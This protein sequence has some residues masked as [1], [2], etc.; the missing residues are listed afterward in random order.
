MEATRFE[1][2]LNVTCQQ[3]DL[4]GRNVLFMP[5]GI[6]IFE[7]DVCEGWKQLTDNHVLKNKQYF[8]RSRW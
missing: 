3:E 7:E 2:L 1:G 8:C 6:G 4:E 5:D